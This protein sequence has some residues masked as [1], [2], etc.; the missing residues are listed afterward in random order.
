MPSANGKRDHR[1][2][3]DSPIRPVRF[4]PPEEIDDTTEGHRIIIEQS[5][6]RCQ[7]M[8][9]RR[10]LQMLNPLLKTNSRPQ[11]WSWH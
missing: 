9:A 1:W 3:S 7:T 11:G 5:I 6:S 2:R 8:C 10:V 4:T